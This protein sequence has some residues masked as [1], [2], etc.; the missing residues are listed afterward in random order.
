MTVS[1]GVL[2]TYPPTQCGLATFSRALVSALESPQDLVGVVRVADAD[3][4][5][6]RPRSARTTDQ[7]AD[8][9]W[10]RGDVRGPRRAASALNRF[11]VAVV[12]HEYGIF[13]GPDGDD[14]ARRRR[15]ASTCPL[16]IVLHTVLQRRRRRTSGD[17]LEPPGRRA[18]SAVVTMTETARRRLLA[19]YAVDPA[20]STVIPH[21]AADHR[22]PSCDRR[23]RRRTA[24]RWSSPGACSGR[25]RASSG[26]STRWPARA[27][28]TRAY[29][30]IGADPPQGAR[31]A[32][33]E[34]YRERPGGP[35]GRGARRR[36]PR[37]AS[38]TATS[39]VGRARASSSSAAD[40]V[41]L[42]YDS[43]EQVTSGVL[44]EA[45]AAGRPW[46]PPPSRMPSSC[47][48]TGPGSWCRSATPRRIAAALRRVLTE[49]GLADA[50]GAAGA[51]GKAPELLWAR[52]RRPLPGARGL[53]C[54][55]RAGAGRR[56]T[57]DPRP[58]TAGPST[59]CAASPTPAGCSSTP[60]GTD[61]ASASTATA[62]TTWPAAW[63]CWPA[64]RRRRRADPRRALP[65]L[66]ARRAGRRRPLPQPARRRPCAG[67]TS[68]RSRTAGA[69][70]SGASAAVA[71]RGA[72][73]PAARDWP[74]RP[75]SAA[76]GSARP[77]RAPM[78]FA[79]LGRG[80][81]PQRRTRA[82]AA[83]AT[84]LRDGGRH[85]IGRP[86]PTPRWPWP[87][88][89]APL[90]QRRAARGAARRRRRCWRA[91]ARR[92]RAALLGWLLDLE[93]ARRAPV[94]DVPVGGWARGRGPA[95][96]RPAAHRGGRAGRRLR[97]APCRHRRPR[98][99]AGVD[100]GRGVVP[101]RQRLR[102]LAARPRDAAAGATGWSPRAATRTRARS[103]PS[104]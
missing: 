54:C 84:C 62:S 45:V 61:A 72:A 68:R 33:G 70:R 35:R 50:A 48:P 39:T 93:T 53:A 58:G 101:R 31:A 40:V 17:I 102:R 98:W 79:A 10:V 80:R 103:R 7:P 22:R 67:P 18:P 55:P 52:R 16:I 38:T 1:Y 100:A 73:E 83:R 97:R 32:H 5:A 82:T 28:S 87:R 65:G 27:T 89:A 43:R 2:S 12:Q 49:P 44:I 21:G 13:G 75:S 42:P 71:A 95:R 104:R 41:L 86:R 11:D 66:R 96:L 25:A 59:T 47:S 14:V 6:G 37:R 8:G 78:A 57:A 29:L 91:P 74:S 90:R 20:R 56:V 4:L 60:R 9:S 81:G 69:G 88:A 46:C 99:A 26:P 15:A 34:A 23:R 30:V 94:G 85:A 36:R 24:A 3:E 51:R 19:G 63:S 64:S 92:R 77:H 76:P